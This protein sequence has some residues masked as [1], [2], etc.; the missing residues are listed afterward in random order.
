MFCVFFLSKRFQSLNMEDQADY[1][2]QVLPSTS[3]GTV[4]Y[5]VICDLKIDASLELK[6]L[7]QIE[8]E[9]KISQV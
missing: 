8:A 3:Q 7:S 6:P 2:D 9:S 4:Q 5:G 1:C